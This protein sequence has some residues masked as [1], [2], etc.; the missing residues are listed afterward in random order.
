MASGVFRPDVADPEMSQA[1]SSLLWELTLYTVRERERGGEV[2]L[3]FS[4]VP[5]TKVTV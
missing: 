4:I 1:G 5:Q 3:V 2:K